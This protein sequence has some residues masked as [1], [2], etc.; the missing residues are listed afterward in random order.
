[1]RSLEST[2]SPESLSRARAR[3][4]SGFTRH[5]TIGLVA[6]LLGLVLG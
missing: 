2:L 4:A 3:L 5:L 6:C 1:M